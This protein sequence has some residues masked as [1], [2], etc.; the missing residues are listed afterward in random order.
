[1]IM[2]SISKT[3]ILRVAKLSQL[4]LSE[5]EIVTYQKEIEDILTYVE[6]LQSLKLDGEA[7]SQVTGLTNVMRKDDVSVNQLGHDAL[8][9]NVKDK[10]A[11]YIKVKRMVG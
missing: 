11:G 5:A 8:M 4:E 2:S 7:T 1:M 9:A 3:D 6:Q 10:S